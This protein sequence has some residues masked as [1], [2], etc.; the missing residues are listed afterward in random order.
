[1]K[2][3]NNVK[4]TFKTFLLWEVILTFK[5]ASQVYGKIFSKKLM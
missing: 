2:P 1:M 3:F 4:N 5:G